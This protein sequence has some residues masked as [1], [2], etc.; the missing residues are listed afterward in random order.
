VP[1]VESL[2]ELPEP[3]KLV[4]KQQEDGAWKYPGKGINPENGENYY[5][6][7]TYRSLRV[8]VEQ[9]GFTSAH[10]AIEKAADFVFS[11]QTADGD[12]RGILGS[13]TMP[14]YH[15]AILELLVKAGLE[16]DPHVIAGLDW[17]LAVRQD[18]G[19]WL[20][21]AMAV[22]PK[23]R[24][25]AFWRGKTVL[26]DPSLP[27]AHLATGM[28][29]RAFA[30]HPDYHQRPEVIRSGEAL[31]ERF[32]Q[33]DKYNDRKA[34][35]Y[36]LKFQFPFWWANLLTALDSL[37]RLGF[38]REDED[39][40]R[41]LAWFVENQEVDGLWP[42]GYGSSKHTPAARHWVGLAACRMLKR[43]YGGQ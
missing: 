39:I 3:A 15:G 7:E 42:I 28:A 25:P 24:T 20:I 8:L 21:P 22:P 34:V 43:F 30:A 1:P 11:C 40:A 31:K 32:L 13:Q 41:G 18:D 5:L 4:R 38:Y 33:A 2:W 16:D 26:A 27:H 36:W 6:L 35:S 10:P 14:Y 19:G 9:Y 29:I 37:G 17:L 12:I 23:E